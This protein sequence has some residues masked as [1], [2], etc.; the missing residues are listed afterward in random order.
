MN[1]TEKAQFRRSAEWKLFRKS[2]LEQEDQD[3]ITQSKLNKKANCH[4]LDMSDENYTDLSN[5]D[6]FIMLNKKTHTMIHQLFSYYKKD[7]HVL[8]RIK[9][10]LDRMMEL[11]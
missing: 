7:P 8:D 5:P 9:D 6:H 10:V 2:L 4:H 1:S 3:Y 11:N